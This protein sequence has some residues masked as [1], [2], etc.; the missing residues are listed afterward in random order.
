MISKVGSLYRPEKAIRRDASRDDREP[1]QLFRLGCHGEA[2]SSLGSSKSLPGPSPGPTAGPTAGPSHG[3]SPRVAGSPR[4]PAWPACLPRPRQHRQ[5]LEARQLDEMPRCRGPTRPTGLTDIIGCIM[6][7]SPA[8]SKHS[9]KSRVP[10]RDNALDK[11]VSG[12]VQARKRLPNG[13]ENVAHF[14]HFPREKQKQTFSCGPGCPSATGSSHFHCGHGERQNAG[15]DI[16]QRGMAGQRWPPRLPSSCHTN[17][18][19][20]ENANFRW[21]CCSFRAGLR[22]TCTKHTAMRIWTPAKS[23]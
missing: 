5:S 17:S 21:P 11:T 15:V 23:A 18:F 20:R 12:V 13:R 2:S 16:P 10:V 1:L 22:C 3:P 4:A 7:Q 9:R 14:P 19:D 8:L 6:D